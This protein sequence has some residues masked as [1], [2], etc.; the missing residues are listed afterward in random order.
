MPVAPFHMSSR[1]AVE[2]LIGSARFEVAPFGVAMKLI[3]P[4][5]DPS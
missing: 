3:E 5:G 1:H 4:G 2:D